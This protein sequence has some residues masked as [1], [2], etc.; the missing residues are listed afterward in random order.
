MTGTALAQPRAI[1]PHEQQ[2]LAKLKSY[3]DIQSLSQ[4]WG[5]AA[6][7]FGSM[8]A[9]V[10]PHAKPAITLSY[11][12]LAIQIQ[13]FAAGLLALG[14]PTSTADDFPPRL[15][16]FADNSPRWL[17]ADQGTLLAGAA[18]AV[19]GAQAEVSE[20]LYVLEDSGSI[21]RAHV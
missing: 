4:I 21:G 17:I 8:P 13:A 15:A 5:R 14:V 3:R 12:E 20:L 9:L 18:N 2:L 7:Q 11:Q 10:A 1:T 16:Q 6:S 19:R